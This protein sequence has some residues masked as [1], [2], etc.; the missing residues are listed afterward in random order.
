MHLCSKIVNRSR[1]VGVKYD[2]CETTIHATTQEGINTL[3][4]D[5]YKVDDD[6]LPDPNNKPSLTGNTYQPV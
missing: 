2:S 6:R 3:L 4:A 5:G 1:R